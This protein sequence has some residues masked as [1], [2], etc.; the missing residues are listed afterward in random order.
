MPPTVLIPASANSRI[1]AAA[2]WAASFTAGLS[3]KTSSNAP[4]STTTLEA[5]SNIAQ[6]Q[7]MPDEHHKIAIAH[8][9][10]G[11]RDH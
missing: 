9:Q 4:N 8:R 5:A 7:R 3:E 11:I 2:A 6:P 1:D 10:D